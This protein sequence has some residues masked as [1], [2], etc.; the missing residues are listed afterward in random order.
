MN[1]STLFNQAH[2][3]TKETL[4]HEEGVYSEVLAISLKNL[5][6]EVAEQKRIILSEA[7]RQKQMAP[8]IFTKSIEEMTKKAINSPYLI[9][10]AAFKIIKRIPAIVKIDKD[11]QLKAEEY[12]KK[13]GGHVTMC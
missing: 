10:T 1:K 5:Y 7:K 12:Y 8:H 11:E 9:G 2:K 13:T 4:K 6:S 3:I